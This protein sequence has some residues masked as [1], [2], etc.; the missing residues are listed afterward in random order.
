MTFSLFG[1]VPLTEH[2]RTP[3]Q[4]ACTGFCVSPGLVS[5]SSTTAKVSLY[6]AGVEAQMFQREFFRVQQERGVNCANSM[7]SFKMKIG[8]I[9]RCIHISS[10]TT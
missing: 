8:C 4:L 2:Q 5:L 10:S 9:Y 1:E 6:I 7:T 3:N